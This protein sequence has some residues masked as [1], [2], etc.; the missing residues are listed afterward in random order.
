M[1]PTP[2]IVLNAL[3]CSGGDT[4]SHVLLGLR[5]R[6]TN[7]RHPGVVS[8]PTIRI[9][10]ALEP[11]LTAAPA[12]VESSFE[13]ISGPVEPIGAR[14]DGERGITQ[15]LVEALLARKLDAGDLLEEGRLL[16]TCQLR[17]LSCASVDD[18]GGTGVHELTRMYTAI[19]DVH[20]GAPL[21]PHS[22]ASYSHIRWVPVDL[23]IDCWDRRDALALVPDANPFEI[24]IRGLCIRSG[25]E[26]LRELRV[27]V[28]A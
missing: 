8:L 9:P 14:P 10:S 15:Y 3:I 12:G 17:M 20:D 26:L 16:G 24:C 18:P 27:S 5:R 21:F 11:L 19:V 7:A 4:P 2:A 6:S 13:S 28:A 25:V 1:A 22:S 23:L